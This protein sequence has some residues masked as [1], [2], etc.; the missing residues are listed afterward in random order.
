[1]KILSALQFREADSYTIKQEKITSLTLME[2][3]GKACFDWLQSK[4]DVSKKYITI[5]GNGNNGG[6]GLVISRLL[7]EK[8]LLYE[9]ILLSVGNPSPDFS[10]NFEKIKSL[11]IPMKELKEGDNLSLPDDVVVIDAI[12]GTGLNRPVNGWIGQCIDAINARG[13]EVIAIDLPSGLFADK[14]T[15]GMVVEAN[16]TLSFQN[17]KLAFFFA[18]N[19]KC[20]GEFH[21]LDIGLSSSFI[22][23]ID[24]DK[25]YLR[26]ED[27][28][29]HF[30]KRKTFSHKGMY[31]HSLLIAGSKGK[32]GAAILASR[33]CL[34]SGTG[35]LTV[36]IP[37]SGNNIVQTSIPEAMVV[38]DVNEDINTHIDL[39]SNYSAIGIG[40]GLGTSELTKE[41]IFE[42]IRKTS[43]PMV[44]DADA[45]NIL[46]AN[47]DELK[48]VKPNSVFTPHPKEF[49]RLA[50]K[51][52][53]DFEK[54]LLQ[55]DY[56]A[57]H[58][59]VIVLKGAFTCITTPD[60]KAYFNSTGNPGMAKGGSGDALT[61]MILAF[62][63]QGYE[64]SLAAILGV[65]LHGLAGDFAAIE[66]GVHSMICSDLIENIPQAFDFIN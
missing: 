3:A 57:R 27:I 50:G 39:N 61:G 12:F 49:K 51:S 62:L 14:H 63:A 41:M 20:V 36:H 52:T 4:K 46:A 40:P 65:Y 31:G 11:N 26:A 7:A 19:E 28:K 59:V 9:V 38:L 5:C 24:S 22:V 37:Q 42:L 15:E 54:H 25:F 30:K 34:R 35:L 13:N 45:L 18:E 29:K 48:N 21:I 23:K 16:H 58:N 8:K 53:N 55:L 6:D 44:F 56:S 17:P 2:R 43:L 33:A 32:I 47:P 66:K 60:G 64:P 1:M 10:A